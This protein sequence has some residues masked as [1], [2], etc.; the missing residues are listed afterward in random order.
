MQV[1]NFIT[2]L[3]IFLLLAILTAQSFA[4]QRC[5]YLRCRTEFRKVGAYCAHGDFAHYCM[6]RSGLDD[7]LL[8]KCPYGQI[9]NEFLNKCGQNSERNQDLCRNFF[10]TRGMSPHGFGN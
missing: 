3:V 9:F 2:I 6:C 5:A 7:A 10:R 8:M 1:V 4:D